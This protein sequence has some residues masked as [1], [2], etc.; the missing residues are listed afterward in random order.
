MLAYP[1]IYIMLLKHYDRSGIVTWS[2]SKTNSHLL[3]CAPT[4]QLEEGPFELE[5]LALDLAEKSKQLSVIGKT[6]YHTRFR[7][8]AWDVLGEKDGSFQNG[9]L[10]GGTEDGGITI[11]D[12]YQI[13]SPQQEGGNQSYPGLVY[14]E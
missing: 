6:S 7:S 8:L 1:G 12:P 10:F 9:L 5:I 3:A 13:T 11:W 14:E 2:N 4:P